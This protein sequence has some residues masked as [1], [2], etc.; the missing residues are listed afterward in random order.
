MQSEM[1]Y[2]RYLKK[3]DIFV[4]ADLEEA[5]PLIVKNT[6]GA[7]NAPIPPSTLSQ[8]GNLCVATSSA[9]DSK[10]VMSAYWV[11]ASQV[12]KT[13]PGGILPTG[14]FIVKG[15][16]NFLAPSQLVLGF[17]VMFQV[18]K[19]SLR[20][21]RTGRFDVYAIAEGAQ[22]AGTT[23]NAESAQEQPA[24]EA[25]EAVGEV[26]GQEQE[27]EP[28]PEPKPKPE[29]EE[30]ESGSGEEDAD[31]LPAR[32]PLQQRVS[33]VPQTT[34]VAPEESDD[35]QGDENEEEQGEKSEEA[36]EN[37]A[38]ETQKDGE[39]A[40]VAP[41]EEDQQLSARERRALRKGQSPEPN[42][43]AATGKQGKQLAPKQA[44]APTRGKKAKSK[45]AAAKYAEQDEE[46]RELALRVL[47]GKSAKTEKAEKAAEA[48]EA[49]DREAQAAK[50][51]RKAQHERAA[52]AERKRQAIFDEGAEEYD[53][54]TA[55]AEA[56]DLSWIPALVGTAHLDDEIIAAI[57]VCAPWAALGRY[58]YRV[59][60]QP[61]SVKKGKAVREIVGRWV[62][63][64][65][66]GKVKKEQAEDAGLSLADAEK[67]RARE[68]EL[69]KTWKD[70]EIINV[71]PVGKVRIMGAAGGGGG[72]GGGDT[73]GKSKGGPPKGVKGGKKK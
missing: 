35:E 65:T 61:G 13:G 26:D 15:D 42:K 8:A 46:E 30:K 39:E 45:K 16:K 33:E 22:A 20:N 58:K 41:Q 68:G 54:E 28:E 59:K 34:K 1:L 21:H 3:G 44:P 50:Q 23:E 56:A 18:S 72:G 47:G 37:G 43:P 57:P 49:R 25:T 19:E 6:P 36:E 70:T 63:E 2:R 32:N 4:H 27:Q 48:K 55:A 31:Q 24:T 52:E 73:K 40:P 10:A 53:E 9:W 67:I 11:Q 64:T 51:R 66:T 60:L 62:S 69:I 71:M 29:E 38:E 7:S 14:Q 17:G 5:T 12:T